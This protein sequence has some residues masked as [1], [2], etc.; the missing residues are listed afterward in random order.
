MKPV[1][2]YTVLLYPPVG[3]P[4][5]VSITMHIP[6]KNLKEIVATQV[7]TFDTEA[8]ANAALEQFLT[9]C[10]EY[11]EWKDGRLPAT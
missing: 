11:R 8:K 7:M 6:K 2:I 5:V 9:E 3:R 1:T 4:R 10:P